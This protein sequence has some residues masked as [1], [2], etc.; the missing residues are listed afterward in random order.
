MIVF[1]KIA[2]AVFF[3]INGEI[4]TE[5]M[6][7]QIHNAELNVSCEVTSKIKKSK[8]FHMLLYYHQKILLLERKEFKTATESDIVCA[9]LN[10]KGDSE[11][12]FI[13]REPKYLTLA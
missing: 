13:S 4:C 5:N 3:F 1:W 10:T 11:T 6:K 7:T 8:P 2:Q 12:I 9:I